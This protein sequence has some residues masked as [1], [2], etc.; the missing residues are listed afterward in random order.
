LNDDHVYVVDYIK[1]PFETDNLDSWNGIEGLIAA[2]AEEKFG[3][4]T[5]AFLRE[6][7]K[8][9]AYMKTGIFR[10]YGLGDQ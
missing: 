7:H 4:G 2:G 6:A 9:Q 5:E 3:E 8:R 1:D 10:R